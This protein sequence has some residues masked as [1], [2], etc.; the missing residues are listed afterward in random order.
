MSA[1]ITSL[2]QASIRIGTIL[3]AEFSMEEHL[4]NLNPVDESP[5]V[6]DPYEKVQGSDSVIKPESNKEDK[7]EKA[8]GLYA[9]LVSGGAVLVAVMLAILYNRRRQRRF[10][11]HY[12]GDSEEGSLFTDSDVSTIKPAAITLRN[13]SGDDTS[14][15]SNMS[16]LFPKSVSGKPGFPIVPPRMPSDPDLV[17]EE[18]EELEYASEFVNT[19]TSALTCLDGAQPVDHLSMKYPEFDMYSSMPPR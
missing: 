12:P 6:S 9:A 14:I 18:K 16:P 1:I 5:Q 8:A 3:P 7:K 13:K 15:L 4:A 10:Q 11:I 2:D 17:G 19:G